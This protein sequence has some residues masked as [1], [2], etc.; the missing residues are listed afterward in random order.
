MNSAIEWVEAPP[1]DGTFIVN[2][3]DLLEGWTNGRFKATQHRVVNTG[4]ERYSLPMFFAVDYHPVVEPLP[5]FITAER[6]AGPRSRQLG[7][8]RTGD[9]GAHFNDR[10]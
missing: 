5:Q 10:P 3:G 9:A 4:Q 7:K 8:R 2:I 6:P 1:L